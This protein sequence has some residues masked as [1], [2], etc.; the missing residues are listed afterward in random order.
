[1][2]RIPPFQPPTYPTCPTGWRLENS[3]CV[4][5]SVKNVTTDPIRVCPAGYYRAANNQCVKDVTKVIEATPTY[6]CPTG[7]NMVNNICTRFR[8]DKG[9]YVGGKEKETVVSPPATVTEKEH[10]IFVNNTIYAPVNIN[11]VNN[12]TIVVPMGH[13][14]DSYIEK[15]VVHEKEVEVEAEEKCC[16]VISPRI[17]RRMPQ[18]NWK[19]FHKRT[20]QCGSCC[21]A[22][23]IYLKPPRPVYRPQF[24]VVPPAPQPIFVQEPSYSHGT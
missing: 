13:T 24:M 12:H 15:K 7:F 8:V 11:N 2:S 3:Q 19:C 21:T 17:C 5:T 1:M 9:G 14:R 16:E 20:Q 10:H 6:V 18:N 22:P 4:Q 23:K